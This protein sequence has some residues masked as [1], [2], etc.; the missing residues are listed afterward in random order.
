M[1]LFSFSK[2]SQQSKLN[3][4]HITTVEELKQA[5]AETDNVTGLFFKHSTRCNISSM[6]LS[7]FESSWEQDDKCEL[8]FID[9]IAHRDV[10][11][12]ISELTDVDHQSPQVIV[13]KNRREIFNASHN[14]ISS[15]EIKN[16]I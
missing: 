9:L 10:S 3:W 13:V 6:A 16:S 14:G 12:A 5:I 1:G 8:Y 2:K 4:I 11:N 15:S 7:R